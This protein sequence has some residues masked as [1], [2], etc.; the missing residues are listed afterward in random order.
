VLVV[1][2]LLAGGVALGASVVG[3]HGHH[4]PAAAGHPT[5]KP[6]P[7]PSPVIHDSPPGG[8]KL[9]HPGLLIGPDGLA[10]QVLIYP[11]MVFTRGLSPYA[12]SPHNG[13]YLEFN[14]LVVSRGLAQEVL[15]PSDDFTVVAGAGAENIYSGN[16]KYSGNPSALE[17][18]FLNDGQYTSGPLMFDTASTHG[19][20]TFDEPGL[21]SCT[22]HF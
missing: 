20:I 17:P 19:I 14:V 13:Y 15:T 16:A 10:V 11:P 22:W 5:T 21:P 3:R 9:G 6:T 7:H 18:T 4:K 12:A 1:V 8:C 2:I